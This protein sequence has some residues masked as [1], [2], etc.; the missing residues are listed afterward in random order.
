MAGIALSYSTLKRALPRFGRHTKGAIAPLHAHYPQLLL[1]VAELSPDV[2]GSQA[3]VREQDEG[4]VHEICDLTGEVVFV[5]GGRGEGGFN[6]FFANLLRDA[7][8]AA[9]EQCGGVAAYGHL[10]LALFNRMEQF[11]K[12]PCPIVSGVVPVRD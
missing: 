3:R 10:L 6:A 5:L 11:V 12:N 4:V 7:S 2:I 8:S 9:F 1:A